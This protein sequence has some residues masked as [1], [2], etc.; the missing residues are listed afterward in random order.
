MP[1]PPPSRPAHRRPPPLRSAA[2][3][4]RTPCRQRRD[5][6]RSAPGRRLRPTHGHPWRP[7]LGP[8]AAARAG[9]A[10][11]GQGRKSQR[12]TR[13]QRCSAPRGRPIHGAPAA[14]HGSTWSTPCTSGTSRRA[15]GPEACSSA[16]SRGPWAAASP[17]TRQAAPHLWALRAN[18]LRRPRGC[19]AGADPRR[20]P[21]APFG[22]RCSEL[23]RC[24]RPLPRPRHVERC[25][26]CSLAAREGSA[27]A[28][29]A[30]RSRA[31]RPGSRA[32]SRRGPGRAGSAAPR[33]PA[34]RARRPSGRPGA[35]GRRGRSRERRPRSAST[36]PSQKTRS[37]RAGRHRAVP[38]AAGFGRASCA[39][40][41][42]GLPA[43]C[44]PGH[45][46]QRRPR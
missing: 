26:P 27:A 33:A 6:G 23:G 10:A 1:P 40:T 44:K 9:R 14:S 5:R 29:P 25:L 12:T 21:R 8:S 38:T 35:P 43:T 19:R 15:D 34:R 41:P 22:R 28:P 45:R 11:R 31:A 39:T 2:A 20:G 18:C 4:G 30:P 42:P 16:R 13:P 37:G 46:Q 36:A 7:C 17:S 3:P 32:S 24:T